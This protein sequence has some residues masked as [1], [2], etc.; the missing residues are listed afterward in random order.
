MEDDVMK[1][2][3]NAIEFPDNSGETLAAIVRRLIHNWRSRRR[4]A[5]LSE[6]D[7]RMLD[8]IGFTRQELDHALSRPITVDA[9]GELKASAVTR[10]LQAARKRPGWGA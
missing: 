6:L 7:D 2:Y 10:R 9:A 8:D 5:R 1:Y 3:A 4:L